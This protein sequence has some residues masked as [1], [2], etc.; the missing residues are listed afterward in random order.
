[1]NFVGGYYEGCTANE[2]D[3]VGKNHELVEHIG[4]SPYQIRRGGGSQEDKDQRDDR[5][6][7]HAL[8]AKQVLRIYLTEHIPAEDR[9]ER[10]EE[11]SDCHEFRTQIRTKHNAEGGLGQVRVV[12]HIYDLSGVAC[13]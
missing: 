6:N 3:D 7:G 12:K 9:G 2:T 1:M 11:Q 13:C 4:Q 10:E 8:L 5:I